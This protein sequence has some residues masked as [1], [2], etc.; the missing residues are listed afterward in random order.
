MNTRIITIF[1]LFAILAF[2]ILYAFLNNDKKYTD[3]YGNQLSEVQHSDG[4]SVRELREIATA[5]EQYASSENQEYPSEEE[6]Y[7]YEWHE[8]TTGLREDSLTDDRGLPYTYV[9]SDCESLELDCHQFKISADLGEDGY[10]EN[11]A[12]GNLADETQYS[13]L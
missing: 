11:D 13:I 10:G 1:L 3:Q 4:N 12:D 6:Y 2:G 7:S 5:L 8:T 9:R